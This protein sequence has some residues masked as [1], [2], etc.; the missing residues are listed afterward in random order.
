MNQ[1]I[2]GKVTD[3]EHKSVTRFPGFARSSICSEQDEN[4][5]FGIVSSGFRHGPRYSDFLNPSKAIG[6][7]MYH[8][9]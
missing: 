8:L 9:L 4:E 3:I 5:D 2:M 6:Y 1:R 7:Y